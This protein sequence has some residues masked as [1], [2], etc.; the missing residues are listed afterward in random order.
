MAK[1]NIHEAKAHFSRYVQEAASGKEVII[2]K[3]GKPVARLVPLG[4]VK[5]GCTLGLLDGKAR[6]PED[7]NAPPPDETLAEFLGK[8]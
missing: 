8:K 3:A 2:A 4:A 6:I 7:F 5:A 1:I